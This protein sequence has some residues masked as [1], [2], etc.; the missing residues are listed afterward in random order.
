MG[1]ILNAN[2]LKSMSLVPVSRIPCNSEISGINLAKYNS[3]INSFL[4]N[5]LS[6]KLIMILMI[7][8]HSSIHEY[9]IYLFHSVKI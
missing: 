4:K 9:I 6:K 5:S 2:L 3:A 1:E 8:I 7:F